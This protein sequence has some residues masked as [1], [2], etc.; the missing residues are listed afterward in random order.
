MRMVWFGEV[1]EIDDNQKRLY[2]FFFFFF[3]SLK[4]SDMTLGI[5][6]GTQS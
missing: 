6:Q 1:M 3:F 2:G 4:S 5:D